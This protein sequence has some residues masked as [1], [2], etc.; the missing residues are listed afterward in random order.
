MIRAVV[1]V[2]AAAAIAAIVASASN[3]SPFPVAGTAF[4]CGA[5]VI[6]S[7]IVLWLVDTSS[8]HSLWFRA[9]A[10][11]ILGMMALWFSAQ[12]TLGAPEYVFMHQRW[13]AAL[14]IGCLGLAA[15]T[16]VSRIRRSVS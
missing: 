15:K 6:E 1:L 5:I 4:F 11:A 7:A 10:A 12:D 16:G 2:G 3:M 8:P 13:L 14:I 9:L